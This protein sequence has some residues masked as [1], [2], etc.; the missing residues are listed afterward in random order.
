MK[1]YLDDKTIHIYPALLK[2]IGKG[3]EGKV[4]KYNNETLKIF[5]QSTYKETMS[6]ETCVML[7]K[8]D[9]TRIL[10]PRKMLLDNYG[11]FKGYT[12]K[13][14]ENNKYVYDIIKKKL[15]YEINELEKEINILSNH[16]ILIN[17][18]HINNLIYDD[19]FRFVD[20][21]IYEYA[22][23]I[24]INEI[25]KHNYIILKDFIFFELLK[26]RLMVEMDNYCSYLNEAYDICENNIG[27]FFEEE[28][29]DEETMNQYIKRI[30]KPI[31]NVI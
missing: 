25:K 15:I 12:T 8:I 19:K 11:E 5:H 24:S 21:G 29:Y 28:M 31:I 27:E 30:A 10:L 17:D 14:I 18:W 20:P 2:C 16:N 1:Y 22:P 23:N 6:A 13:Y 4:Y 9:T 3:K 7:K 26:Q